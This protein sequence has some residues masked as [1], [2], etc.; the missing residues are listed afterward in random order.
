MNLTR[1]YGGST[2]KNVRAEAEMKIYDQLNQK[3]DEFLGLAQYNWNPSTVKLQPSSYLIDLI[4][5]LKGALVRTK[6][7]L[8][9]N[10]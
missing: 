9:E 5:Y 8:H 7:F 1:L 3:M 4:D 6:I 10:Q 2:L